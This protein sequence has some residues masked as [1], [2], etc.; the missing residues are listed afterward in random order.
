ML[1]RIA[2]EEEISQAVTPKM[3]SRESDPA[4]CSYDTMGS[5]VPP[6]CTTT[7]VHNKRQLAE[8][9]HLIFE[10]HR[11]YDRLTPI[12]ALPRHWVLTW[13]PFWQ[14]YSRWK[15][16]GGG[17][18]ARLAT[19]ASHHLPVVRTLDREFGKRSGY[20]F[21]SSGL[22]AN[23]ES[24]LDAI[25]KDL[26]DILSPDLPA[27]HKLDLIGRMKSSYSCLAR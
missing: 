6:T 13:I 9:G 4:L 15:A 7:A 22:G 27:R 23:V 20:G 26:L 1:S 10:V 16:R 5:D 12:F 2:Q 21:H 8:N 24:E 14:Q 18:L 3:D 25:R 11:F 17:V 19:S